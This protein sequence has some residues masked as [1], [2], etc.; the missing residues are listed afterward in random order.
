MDS[1]ENKMSES[2]L[3]L[4]GDEHFYLLNEEGLEQ[5]L[6]QFMIYVF[7]FKKIS[8]LWFDDSK[9]L[10]TTRLTAIKISNGSFAPSKLLLFV[11]MDSCD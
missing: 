9:I 1:I 4:V 6:Q 10:N 3:F 8:S 2:Q 5:S 7:N 11:A